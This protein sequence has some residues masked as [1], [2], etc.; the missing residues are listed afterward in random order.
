MMT[1]HI[2]SPF[3]GGPASIKREW[4]ATKGTFRRESFPFC[5]HYA[6]C[7]DTGKEFSTTELDRLNA[8]QV[9]N[10]Y[11][12]KHAIPFPQEITAIREQY[13]LS[14]AKMS[15]VLDFGINSYRQY[16]LGEIP[17]LANAKL[18]RLARSA[19]NFLGFAEEKKSSFS[20]KAYGKLMG[21]IQELR[22]ND[23]MEP[24]MRYIWNEH[25]E[26]NRYT[27]YVK[28]R[29]EKVANYILFFAKAANPLKTRMNKLLFYCDFLHFKRTGFSVSGCNYRAIQMGPVPSHFRELFGL[30]ESEQYIHIE[31]EMFDHGG[32]G[33]RF[34]PAR[35]FEER[36]FSTEEL[37]SMEDTLQAFEGV[38]TRQ[39]IASSHEERAWLENQEQRSLISY[40]H[41]AY[42]LK[43]L[44]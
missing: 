26:P 13:G 31:E 30:L 40:L 6:V 33:E 44:D 24:L 12:E 41:Y 39:I 7:Q 37:Q 9:Y 28:P 38:R 42:E 18:I 16:E 22:S 10:Q 19:Q 25:M 8:E 21:R 4:S 32:I 11:R 20:D 23:R 27:G 35:A 34:M 3:T 2:K 14:A 36:W 17:S 1:Q 43:A 29:L 15:E 5:H